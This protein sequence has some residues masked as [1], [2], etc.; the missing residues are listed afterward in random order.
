[1]MA[2]TAPTKLRIAL[3]GFGVVGSR[4][5]H[6]LFDDSRKLSD[7]IGSEIDFVGIA[8][9]DATKDHQGLPDE[10]FFS[11]AAELIADGKPDVVI[12]LIGGLGAADELIRIAID[13]GA[14]VVTANKALLAARGQEIFAYAQRTGVDLYFEAAVAGA[15]PI[16]RPI[17][18]SLVGDQIYS[19]SGIVNG[20]TNYILD[21]MS[22]QGAGYAEA[23]SQAQQLGFAEMDPSADVDGVDAAN[24]IALLASL[25]FGSWV[26]VSSVYREGI[27]ELVPG[28]FRA[29]A[30]NGCVIK[31]LAKAD[32]WDDGSVSARVHPAMVPLGHPLAAIGGANNAI[33]VRARGA[34]ELMFYGLGAGGTPTASAVIG[35]VVTVG[36]NRTR[37]IVGPSFA[38]SQAKTVL[39]MSANE[40]QYFLRFEVADVSG[41]LSQVGAVLSRHAVSVRNLSQTSNMAA[42][43]SRSAELGILTHVTNEGNMKSCVAELNTV[44]FVRGEVR[45]MRVEG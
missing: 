17:S 36:R 24:K 25:S 9:R 3:L 39:P 4:V 6:R 27:T 22:S 42:E 16:I 7:F 15:I 34:G 32:L 41:I 13:H 35:D 20:T 28:D 31:L 18:E 23:L 11:D 26:G 38:M 21:Q 30:A 14:S 10:L 1:M 2:T 45:V 12:E 44:S 43:P 5:A 37:G 8:E 29:A 19:I 40:T 33:V